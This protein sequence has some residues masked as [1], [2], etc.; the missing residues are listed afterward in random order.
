MMIVLSVV[1]NFAITKE[2]QFQLR[3]E[4]FFFTNSPQFSNPAAVFD[5]AN[6]GLITS[7]SIDNRSIQLGGKL[8]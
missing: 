1:K 3:G 8:I 2:V 5:N 7:T 6:F 4:A